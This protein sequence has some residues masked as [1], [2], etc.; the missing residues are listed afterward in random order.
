MQSSTAARPPMT[1]A[2]AHRLAETAGLSLVL[3]PGT[4]SGYRGV[5]RNNCSKDL[6][7]KSGY[8]AQFCEA[9]KT[10]RLGS[11]SSAAEA[12]LAYARHLG[13]VTALQELE[14]REPRKGRACSNLEGRGLGARGRRP[15]GM[16]RSQAMAEGSEGRLG[17]RPKRRHMQLEMEKLPWHQLGLPHYPPPFHHPFSASPPTGDLA[18]CQYDAAGY[19][20]PPY[21]QQWPMGPELVSQSSKV[22]RSKGFMQLQPMCG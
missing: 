16:P 7:P 5:S 9:G 4:F 13:A 1:E 2:E 14:G 17:T 8:C 19:P 15:Y 21:R 22:A 12:A 3:A 18:H 10:V 6:S 20:L 11:F